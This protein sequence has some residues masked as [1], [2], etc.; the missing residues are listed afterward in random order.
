MNAAYTRERT[1]GIIREIVGSDEEESE[2]SSHTEL[3]DIEILP[4]DGDESRDS[5]E[6]FMKALPECGNSDTSE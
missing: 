2:H 4:S 6:S 3:S 1:I 5:L